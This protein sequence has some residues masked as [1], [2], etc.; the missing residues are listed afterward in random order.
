LVAEGARIGQYQFNF[1][2]LESFDQ[3]ISI[4]LEDL[5]E[6]KSINV[7][8]EREYTF[9]VNE[10][11]IGSLSSRFRITIS[12]PKLNTLVKATGESLCEDKATASITIK[13][14]EEGVQYSA[15]WKGEKLSGTEVGTGSTIQLS[16]NATTLGLGENTITVWATS[17]FCSQAALIESP[18]ISKIGKDEISSV[19]D[20]VICNEGTTTLGAAGAGDGGFYNWYEDLASQQPIA[21]QQGGEFITPVLIKSKTYYVAAVNSLGCESE[22]VAVT[23]VVSY[24]TEVSL[25]LIDDLTLKSSQVTGNQWYL[26]NI[27]IENETLDVLQATEPGVY[28]LTVNQ[29]G[30]IMSMSREISEIAFEGGTNVESVIKIYPNPT[31]DKV[32]VQVRSKN[33]SV[34]AIILSSTGMEMESKN[35]TGDNDVK[36]GEFDLVKY[37]A[38]IYTIRIMDGSKQVIKKIA[39]VN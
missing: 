39:K 6:N 1:N 7:G 24:P 17:G 27:L 33:V 19:L 25:T 29:G 14:S 2:G 31:Q 34:K 28:T 12:A 26:N 8:S 11:N 23:A 21:G 9:D 36:E 5:L 20:G 32:R 18:V 15:T 16:V 35:L 37:S 4:V 3:N 38:G 30:C 13:D 10:E 22:R